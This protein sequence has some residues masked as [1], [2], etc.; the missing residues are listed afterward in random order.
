MTE[1]ISN[2]KSQDPKNKSQ[3]TN[4]KIQKIKLKSQISMAYSEALE[5]E[6]EIWNL[7]GTCYLRFGIFTDRIKIIMINY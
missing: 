4:I 5:L 1:K 3:N 7:F 2:Y 6:F